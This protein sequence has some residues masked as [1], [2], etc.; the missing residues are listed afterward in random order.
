MDSNIEIKA[1]A[2]DFGRQ[3]KLAEALSDVSG[4]QFWQ[5]D[6]FFDIPKGRLKLRVFRDRSGELIY[7]ERADSS[8]PK[9]SH[10]EVSKTNEPDSLRHVLTLSLGV[11]GVIRKQRTLYKS[12]HTRI[13]FDEVE[14]LG[15][16]IEL[17]YVMQS[18]ASEEEAF[19][20][21][22]NLMGRLEIRENDLIDRA[23]I[24]LIQK[25]HSSLA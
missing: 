18:T 4:E 5:E 8:G 10:Y 16:F 24:D 9:V 15:D 11:R 7:Y 25:P 2:K 14:G 6:I 21:V 22:K 17:E 3:R 12:G 23:Y 13:H 20:A 1:R 19:N